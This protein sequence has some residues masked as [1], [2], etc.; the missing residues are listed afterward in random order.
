MSL[1]RLCALCHDPWG[2]ST[3]SSIHTMAM[4][5]LWHALIVASMAGADALTTRGIALTGITSTSRR[6]PTLHHASS[7]RRSFVVLSAKKKFILF[8]II[9]DVLDYL[10][11]MGGYTGF[12]EEEL[13]GGVGSTGVDLNQKDMEAFGRQ[14]PE[15]AATKQT[16]DVFVVLLIVTPIL[17]LFAGIAIFGPPALFP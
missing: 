10:T 12:T 3:R 14:K 5:R 1:A 17:G 7:R 2:K 11:N 9:D 13:K 8:Q 6:A 16:T 15:D 4:P